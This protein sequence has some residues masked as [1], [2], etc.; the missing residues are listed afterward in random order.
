MTKSVE[1][2][3]GIRGFWGCTAGGVCGAGG[4]GGF[5]EETSGVRL[6][7][8]AATLLWMR[9]GWGCW[10]RAPPA[11]H[12]AWHTGVEHFGPDIGSLSAEARMGAL[13]PLLLRLPQHVLQRPG[14]ACVRPPA[15]CGGGALV[16]RSVL[17]S[18]V[19]TVWGGVCCTGLR[20]PLPFLLPPSHAP[21]CLQPK[22]TT[23]AF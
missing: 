12:R 10:T 18:E 19:P 16:S 9:Q 21:P 8:A 13:R 6:G 20:D 4:R 7:G 5:W 17:P 11:R 22:P 1:C 15:F 23:K 14:R 2:N 3:E